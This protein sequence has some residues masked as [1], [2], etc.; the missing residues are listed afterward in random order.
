MKNK[1]VKRMSDRFELSFKN[2]VVRLWLI[3]MVPTVIVQIYLIQFTEYPRVIS[4]GIPAISLMIFF[5]WLYFL[6]RKQK[7]GQSGA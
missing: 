6:K 4:G 2:K 5:S 7:E 3:L 1:G